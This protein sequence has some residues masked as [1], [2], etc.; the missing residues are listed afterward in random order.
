MLNETGSLY[1]NGISMIATGL[2]GAGVIAA[3]LIGSAA[4]AEPPLSHL[5]APA[6]APRVLEMPRYAHVFV[7]I[8]EN[9]KTEEIVPSDAAPNLTG[10][11]QHYGY[12]WRFYAESHPSEPNYIAMLGGDTFG[13]RDDDAFWC[14]P[15]TK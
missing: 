15:K 2:C 13:I 14:K 5:P 9:H 10:F 6:R 7:I 12:S 8:E 3:V 11:A 4:R 1:L